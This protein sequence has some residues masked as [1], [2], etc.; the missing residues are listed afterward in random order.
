MFLTKN[1][2]LPNGF[3]ATYWQITDII[4]DVTQG[5]AYAKVNGFK[6]EAAF[7]AG[8]PKVGEWSVDFVMDPSNEAVLPVLQMV[9]GLVDAGLEAKVQ[10]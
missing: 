5:K 2:T 6:D 8:L 4:A 10:A 3:V 7:L 9:S 1:I